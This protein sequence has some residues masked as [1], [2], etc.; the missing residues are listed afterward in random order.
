MET[1]G[2]CLCGALRYRAARL[3]RSVHYCHC[4]MCRRATGG[5]FA[6]LAWFVRDDVSWEGTALKVRRSSPI[7]ERGFCGE[8]GTPLFLRYDGRNDIALTAG[9]LD[10]PER[11]APTHHYG[12]EGRLGWADCG[13]GL[14][15]KETQETF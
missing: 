10:H 3:P 2:G 6:V 14:R 8:C 12:I 4:G 11:F 13:P 15:G 1:Q 5:P 7:A 9:S